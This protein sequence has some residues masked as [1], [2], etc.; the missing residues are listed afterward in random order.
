MR[1]PAVAVDPRPEW[2]S[3]VRCDRRRIDP[4]TVPLYPFDPSPQPSA[5]FFGLS[6]LLGPLLLPSHLILLGLVGCCGL[7]IA[8]RSRR[9]GQIGTALL[10]GLLAAV[11][12][13]PVA[14]W[15]LAPLEQRFPR[16]DAERLDRLPPRAIIVLGGASDARLARERGDDALGPAADRLTAMIALARRYP[17]TAILY[18]G[19]SGRLADQRD[20]EADH[21]MRL[22]VRLG[23]P[24][25][26]VTAE[27]DAR[28]TAENGRAAAAWL[29]GLAPPATRAEGRGPILLVTSAFHM[30]RAV[31]VMHAL[32][33]TVTAYPVDYRTSLQDKG[34]APL[35]LAEGLAMLDLAG[36]EWLG[37]AAYRLAGHTNAWFPAP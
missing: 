29:A 13:T 8:R 37:L 6:K 18:S 19:G 28:N 7:M 34:R 31:G 2:D 10:T 15:T 9:A 32:G 25:D 26:R 20:R 23:L 4:H 22:L 11:V 14:A 27:R 1:P 17:E 33:I 12:L 16:P 24:T 35:H 36:R 30:P 3:D 5:L 21:V